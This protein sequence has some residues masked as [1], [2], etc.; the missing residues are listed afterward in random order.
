MKAMGL[1]DGTQYSVMVA[2]EKYPKDPTKYH[3]HFVIHWKNRHR[4]MADVQT[5]FENQNMK[6]LL[7]V[8]QPGQGLDSR[9]P[10]CTYLLVWKN[11]PLDAEPLLTKNFHVPATVKIAAVNER[12]KALKR[13]MTHHDAEAYLLQNKTF[14]DNETKKEMISDIRKEV[15]RLGGDKS[16]G[17]LF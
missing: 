3:F 6:V 12:E 1:W 11:K 9:V 5:A 17:I 8:I 2:K 4:H 15:E 16:M 7:E 14:L 10:P 13:P